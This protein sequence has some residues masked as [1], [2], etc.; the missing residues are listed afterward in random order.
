AG[1]RSAS[2][3]LG[4][5]STKCSNG[6]DTANTGEAD[7][8]SCKG[9]P[10]LPYTLDQE[11]FPVPAGYLVLILHAH[12]PYV[13]HTEREYTLEEDWLYEAITE[14]YI[15]LLLIMEGWENDGVPYRLTM[16]ITPTLAAMLEDDLL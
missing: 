13:K 1:N 7:P 15:P 8:S 10:S 9:P 3:P 6:Q 5:P 4:R 14:T 16:S 2:T 12:L 11:V